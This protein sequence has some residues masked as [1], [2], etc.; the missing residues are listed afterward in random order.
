MRASI[1]WAPMAFKAVQQSVSLTCESVASP[2]AKA[3]GAFFVAANTF[4]P[5]K[6]APAVAASRQ[7]ESR[8]K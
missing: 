6:L 1:P 7:L 3:S 4:W 5:S 2:Q 8:R